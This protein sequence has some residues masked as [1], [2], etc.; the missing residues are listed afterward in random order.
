MI[1][2]GKRGSR[3][4]LRKIRRRSRKNLFWWKGPPYNAGDWVGPFLFKAITSEE[5]NYKETSN[6]SFSTVYLTVGSLTRWVCQ[7]SII[8]GSGLLDRD[9]VFWE[10]YETC[11][12]RGPYTRDRFLELGYSCPEVYG[13]PAILLPRYFNPTRNIQYRIGI[14]P[15]YSNFKEVGDLYG[16]DH[17]VFVIDIR[18]PL[19]K[20]IRSILSCSYIVSSS[21]HGLIFAHSYGVPAGHVE[22][23]VKPGG[24]GIKFLDYYAAG[25]IQTPPKP[26]IIREKH[27]ISYLEQYAKTSPQ[28]NIELLLNP[29]LE[30]CPF[31]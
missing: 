17:E 30:V 4:V 2:L 11:A 5:P 9:E 26:L 23:S 31:K 8:W 10:P 7:D 22:F 27:P 18:W 1:E 6:R 14:V 19:E 3:R 21:L 15:H 28:P 20:V 29:L 24:D 13:D 25:H 12:V 16:Q